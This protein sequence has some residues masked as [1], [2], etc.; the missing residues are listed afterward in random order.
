MRATPTLYIVEK[1]ERKT[2]SVLLRFK[3]YR[4]SGSAVGWA[5]NTYRP[6]YIKF[7][8][9][10]CIFMRIHQHHKYSFISTGLIYGDLSV[11]FTIV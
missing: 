1:L 6:I 7:V 3:V 4:A 11:E 5:C 10:V 9:R 2:I 8:L